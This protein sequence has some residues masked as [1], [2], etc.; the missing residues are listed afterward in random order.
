MDKVEVTGHWEEDF[1]SSFANVSILEGEGTVDGI[2]VA[3]GSH[4]I[5]PAG[6]GTVE[7][8]GR[9]TFISSQAV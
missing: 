5:V 1:G 7:F 8:K 9:I 2:S 4:F 6:Y 3:K